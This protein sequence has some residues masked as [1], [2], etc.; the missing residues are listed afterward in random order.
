MSTQENLNLSR[1]LA[2]SSV[3]LPNTILIIALIYFSFIVEQDSTT[4]STFRKFF[5]Y[6]LLGFDIL[7]L[8]FINTDYFFLKKVKSN[9]TKFLVTW[10]KKLLGKGELLQEKPDEIKD[11]VEYE[12]KDVNYFH[13]LVNLYNKIS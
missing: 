5:Y 10:M 2:S 3:I 12:F 9:T 6:S 7:A 11:F 1:T 8:V 13:I 4:S